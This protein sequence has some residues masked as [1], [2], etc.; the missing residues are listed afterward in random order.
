MAAALRIG[1]A[2]EV[3]FAAL[4]PC[5]L[6]GRLRPTLDALKHRTATTGEAGGPIHLVRATLSTLTLWRRAC[7]S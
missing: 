6:G 7:E 5:L 1:G 2:K 4:G 3:S